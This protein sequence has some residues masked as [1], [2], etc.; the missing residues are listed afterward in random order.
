VPVRQVAG[1]GDFAS[2]QAYLIKDRKIIY[3][4]HTGT[5]EKQA[6]VILK[7]LAGHRVGS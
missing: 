7:V 3:T 4:D 5:T 6:E 1:R 2:R